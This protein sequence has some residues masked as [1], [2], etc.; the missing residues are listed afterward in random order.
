[1][2]KRRYHRSG[3]RS[4]Y[5]KENAYLVYFEEDYWPKK[6]NFTVRVTKIVNIRTKVAMNRRDPRWN[7]IQKPLCDELRINLVM[8]GAFSVGLRD[9]LRPRRTV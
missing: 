5:H 6:R 9:H 4:V 2:A 8:R 3:R 7:H 1:M